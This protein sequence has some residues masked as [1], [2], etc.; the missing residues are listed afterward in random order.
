MDNSKFGGRILV[1]IALALMF[2]LAYKEISALYQG[3]Q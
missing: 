1:I 3:G 2:L